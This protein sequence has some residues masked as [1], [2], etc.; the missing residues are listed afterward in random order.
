ML[1]MVREQAHCSKHQAQPDHRTALKQEA[2]MAISL[3]RTGDL[4]QPFV[5]VLIPGESGAGKTR[6]AAHLDDVVFLSAEEGLLS[7][8]A[9]NKPYITING[10]LDLYEAY[11]WLT[12]SA[13]AKQ[14]NAV[15]VDS[16]SEI[17]E[18]VLAAERR[19]GVGAKDPRAAYGEMQDKMAGVIRAFRDLS[20]R[21]VVMTA[22][23]EKGQTDTKEIRY[24]AS[25]P[26]KRLTS[27]LPYF[28]D[29]VIPV[30]V[31]RTG[32]VVERVFQCHDDGIWHAKDRSGAL[33]PWEPYDLK[34]LIAKIGG[35]K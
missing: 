15:A 22:K 6:A 34:A 35:A 10:L 21:H 11:E 23:M 12:S 13:E 16:I 4:A 28:F 24:V 18:V 14:F 17:A 19:T 27:D 20:N 5:K 7:I 29:E 9:E 31:H 25:M 8:R 1:D 33:D 2:A 3:K 32:D 26:G 30:R